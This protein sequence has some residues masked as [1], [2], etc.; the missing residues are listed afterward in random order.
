MEASCVMGCVLLSWG[1][2]P[3]RAHITFSGWW[4]H[5]WSCF[6]QTLQP[7]LLSSFRMCGSHGREDKSR[8]GAGAKSVPA[9]SRLLTS[10]GVGEWMRREGSDW[11][12]VGHLG[13]EKGILPIGGWQHLK[14]SLKHDHLHCLPLAI[15]TPHTPGFLSVAN[16]WDPLLS[17]S[18]RYPRHEEIHPSSATAGLRTT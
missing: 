7:N 1:H 6:P 5:E 4:Q 11:L 8:E 15:L 17:L 10:A 12:C 14:T 13:D 16:S 3:G 2:I 18:F 9:E